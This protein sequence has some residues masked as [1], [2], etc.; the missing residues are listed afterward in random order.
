MLLFFM[1][2]FI[3]VK[4][5]LVVLGAYI[6]PNDSPSH[7]VKRFLLT[8]KIQV[9]I[10]EVD[11]NGKEHLWRSQLLAPFWRLLFTC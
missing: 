2:Q 6:T 8:Y 5:L 3:C 11:D 10:L 9:N 4:V 7:I 1:G